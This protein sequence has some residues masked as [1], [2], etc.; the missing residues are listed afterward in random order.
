MA[1]ISRPGNQKYRES[2]DRIF[3]NKQIKMG[4]LCGN[5][6]KPLPPVPDNYRGRSPKCSHCGHQDMRK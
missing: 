1:I 5:C 3:G 2:Y 4:R 6:G